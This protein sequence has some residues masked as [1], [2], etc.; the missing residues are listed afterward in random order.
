MYAQTDKFLAWMYKEPGRLINIYTEHGGTKDETEQLIRKLQ[1]AEHIFLRRKRPKPSRRTCERTT[2]SFFTLIS[3]TMTCSISIGP[4]G[5]S[6][7]DF[8]KQLVFRKNPGRSMLIE[9]VIVLEIRVKKDKVVRSQVR[10]LGFGLFRRKN[11][12]SAGL[13]LS[14]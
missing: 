7:P 14:Y 6:L 12:C 3:S 5:I 10:R 9:H 8:S 1:P 13:K 2:L 11:M 4:S